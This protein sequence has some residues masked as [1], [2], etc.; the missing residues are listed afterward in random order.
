MA[1]DYQKK[2]IEAIKFYHQLH[3]ELT[4]LHMKLVC[5]EGLNS[6]NALSIIEESSNKIRG[7]DEKFRELVK[8][9]SEQL[10]PSSNKYK[11]IINVPLLG[12]ESNN[13]I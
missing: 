7:I 2:Y 12:T 11:S 10:E 1:T 13:E 3:A 8:S 4:N 9:K 6:I 5:K